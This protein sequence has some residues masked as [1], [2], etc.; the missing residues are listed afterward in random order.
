MD[1]YKF[2]KK[3]GG[4]SLV[5]HNSVCTARIVVINQSQNIGGTLTLRMD[6]ISDKCFQNLNIP[7][8]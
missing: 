4:T 6:E 3:E 8:I 1:E 2:S 5:G 7:R